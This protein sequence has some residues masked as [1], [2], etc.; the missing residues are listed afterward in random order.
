M[1]IRG[2]T[3]IKVKNT[4]KSVSDK[5]GRSCNLFSSDSTEA[6]RE[7]DLDAATAG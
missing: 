1:I 6:R 2:R 4:V 3:L 5:Y 7:I